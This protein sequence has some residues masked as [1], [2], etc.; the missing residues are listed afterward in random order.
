MLGIGPTGGGQNFGTAGGGRKALTR[1]G[2][3]LAPLKGWSKQVCRI[4]LREQREPAY[5]LSK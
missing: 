1:H 4:S 2:F 3:G 5:K